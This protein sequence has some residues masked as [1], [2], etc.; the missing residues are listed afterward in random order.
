M[1]RIG[2]IAAALCLVLVVAAVPGNQPIDEAASQLAP[3]RHPPL[4]A[5]PTLLWLAPEP[6]TGEVPAPLANFMT[7]VELYEDGQYEPA[8]DRLGLSPVDGP[9][10]SYVRFYTGRVQLALARAA[11]ARR[12]FAELRNRAPLGYLAEASAFGEAEAAEALGDAAGASRIYAQLAA[13][14]TLAPEQAWLGLGRTSAL[15]G[16][17][18]Q[19]ATAFR[20]V[21]YRYPLG[22]LAPEADQGLADL[23]DMP[24]LGPREQSE[25]E[26]ARALSLFD[27]GR[28]ADARAALLELRPEARGDELE[29]IEVRLAASEVELGR[30]SAARDRL[31][32]YLERGSR[33]AEAAYW[34]LR[35]RRG[36][37]RKADFVRRARWLVDRFPHTSWAEAALDALGTHHI[38]EDEDDLA[39][40]AFREL[41]ERFPSG[42]HAERAAWQ[43]GWAAYRQGRHGEVVDVF[44]RAATLHPRSNYRPAYLYWSGRAYAH[45]ARTELARARYELAITDYGGSYYG[46]PAATRLG[47]LE[48][49]EADAGD[50]PR[51]T[52]R[53]GARPA[54]AWTPP[55]TAELIRLLIGIGHFDAA[56]NEI[57]WASLQWGES[58]ALLATEALVHNRR[59][60]LRL[61]I[62]QMKRAYPHYLT[63]NAGGLPRAI[64]EILYPL[65]YW[66]LIRRHARERGLD[67]Y[68]VAA[69]IA[70][71]S[72]FDAAVRSSA[73]A[74]GLMQVVPATGQRFARAAGVRYSRRRLTDPETNIR[75]GTTFFQ[76]L[77]TET[78]A[79]HLALAGYNAG[80]ARVRQWLPERRDLEPDEFIEDIPFPETRNYVKRVLGT[81]ED[82]RQLYGD[83]AATRSAVRPAVIQ[84]PSR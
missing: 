41:F 6:E 21:R 19:A 65:D 35:A 38:I 24:P 56:L 68:L 74:Y 49:A 80:D 30:H 2:R 69:L 15:A 33:Q 70:Q 23:T 42:R 82:Y 53:T 18:D 63:A 60:E 75:L 39:V 26:L 3:T 77:V 79:L 78:G 36:Q 17:L 66:D 72:N 1:G 40:E 34:D 52:E 59:G 46:R 12:T 48:S 8:L 22:D 62:N 51:V 14:R 4:P 9:L 44:E 57:R 43:L 25:R 7:A 31:A 58:P 55:P 27:A 81:A 83:T 64:L 76:R 67:P 32:A 61:A 11:E 45:L 73:N 5:D 71:E 37:G 20:E 13:A 54:D 16:D 28:H 29:L 50:A 10:E 47:R 84:V